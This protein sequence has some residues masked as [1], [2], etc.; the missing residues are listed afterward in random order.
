MKQNHTHKKKVAN[1]KE[2]IKLVEEK[3]TIQE[4]ADEV[5]VTY[6]T[7]VKYL[8]EL[9]KKYDISYLIDKEKEK[10]VLDYLNSAEWDGTK[11]SIKEAVSENIGY[12]EITLILAKN[13]LS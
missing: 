5:G 6:G 7:I 10:E 4:I 12:D 3:R 13:K 9:P 11:K 1:K 8:C 2:V